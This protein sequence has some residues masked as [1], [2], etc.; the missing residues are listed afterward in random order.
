MVKEI[1]RELK[2]VSLSTL[3]RILDRLEEQHGEEL[4]HPPTSATVVAPPRATHIPPSKSNPAR[5]QRQLIEAA[6][7]QGLSVV[8]DNTNPT[9]E[10]RAE[11][12]NLGRLYAAEIIGYYFAV[13]LEQ[14]LGN[15][16]APAKGAP[17]CQMWRFLPRSR[18]SLVP[19][20][21]KALQ[22]SS[23]CAIEATRISRCTIG[24]RKKSVNDDEN[25][26]ATPRAC[27]A[28]TRRSRGI[29]TIIH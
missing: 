3:T 1:A 11:L 27:V 5:R 19:R 8:V 2:G 14:C 21:Q 26:S 23:M 7:Q 20:M 17:G 28:S 10:V 22:S 4:V 9:K 24:K 6:L 15:A 18:G 16:T 29:F 12:I 25:A 13:Q